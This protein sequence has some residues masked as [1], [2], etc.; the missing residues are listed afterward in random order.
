MPPD[1]LHVLIPIVIGAGILIVSDYLI[2][3][4][5]PLKSSRGGPWLIVLLTVEVALLAGVWAWLASDSSAQVSA[6]TKTWMEKLAVLLIS[7][8][9]ITLLGLAVNIG[10]S[11]SSDLQLD[12]SELAPRR[13][14]LI[15]TEGAKVEKRLA[16]S[17]EQMVLID[18]PREEQP[19]QVDRRSRPSAP[20]A[21]VSSSGGWFQRVQRLPVLR[22]LLVR[23]QRVKTLN[24]EERAI[25]IFWRKDIN[26]RLLLLGAPGSG[27]TTTLLTLAQELLQV[28]QH[29][30]D[31]PLAIV[32]ELSAWRKELS[33]LDWLAAELKQK[34]NLSPT[35]SQS[36][37]ECH[38]T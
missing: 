4:L 20:P 6:A 15:K 10:Q 34:Y 29:D 27:K 33:I 8:L 28:A 22:E 2:N 38:P 3:Q 23:N 31:H 25:D 13:Q 35:V 11:R 7:V 37:L 18:L 12:I 36:L 16:D 1:I 21:P 24:A 19:E 26:G 30:P 9:L 14:Q 5:P 32:F 17:L